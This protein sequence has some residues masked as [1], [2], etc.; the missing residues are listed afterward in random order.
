MSQR[1]QT[2]LVRSCWAQGDDGAADAVYEGIIPLTAED[3]ADQIL[4]VATR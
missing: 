2:Y 1:C 4:Y 3:I